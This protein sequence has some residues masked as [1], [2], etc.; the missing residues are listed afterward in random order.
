MDNI[1]RIYGQSVARELMEIEFKI[2]EGG[3]VNELKGQVHGYVTNPNYRYDITLFFDLLCI[4]V[5]FS[6][7]ISVK[8]STFILFINDRLVENASLKRE[9]VAVYSSYLPK[10]THPFIYLSIHVPP[11]SIDVNVHPTKREVDL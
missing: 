5:Y 6:C 1:R 3:D 11:E 2:N 10:H 9:C 8:K 7:G 4:N